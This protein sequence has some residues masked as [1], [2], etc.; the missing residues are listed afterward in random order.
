[1]EVNYDGQGW[2]TICDDLWS[3]Q[4]GD[5]V[6]RMLGYESAV[7]AP[8]RA[9]YGEGNGTIWFDDVICKGTE[10]TL[11]ECSFAGLRIHNCHHSKDASVNC[12]SE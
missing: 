1:M 7:S 11:L 3:I 10:A 2:G 9:F 12:S 8:L 5:V 4:D 6:C